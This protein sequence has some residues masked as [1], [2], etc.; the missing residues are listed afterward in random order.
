MIQAIT[1]DKDQ[2]VASLS[3]I[4]KSQEFVDSLNHVILKIN[5]LHG[6]I[7]KEIDD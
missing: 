4:K 5:N 6:V 2:A 3:Q 1:Q 7:E